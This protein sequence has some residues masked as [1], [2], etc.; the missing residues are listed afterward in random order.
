MN[1]PDSQQQLQ[2]YSPM[3]FCQAP[4]VHCL[5]AGLADPGPIAS[6]LWTDTELHS[7]VCLDSIVTVVD[8]HNLRK[9]LQEGSQAGDVN[10]AERQIAFADTILLNKVELTTQSFLPRLLSSQGIQA[11]N[12]GHHSLQPKLMYDISR[13]S[14]MHEVSAWLWS[15]ISCNAQ[16][17][18]LIAIQ[19]D[20]VDAG[21]LAECLDIIMG[22]NSDAAIVQTQH[23]SVPVTRLLNQGVYC[24]ESALGT[25]SGVTQ[26]K[27]STSAGLAARREADGKAEASRTRGQQN[28][29]SLNDSSPPHLSAQEHEA[30]HHHSEE[31]HGGHTS[32]IST[33]ALHPPR[34]V[35]LQR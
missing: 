18:L 14:E 20:L 15:W 23:S 1:N 5:Q 25:F 3:V 30:P 12:P 29:D 24:Q 11:H 21:D 2:Y 35:P 27:S 28:C 34:P 8:A 10:E 32:R 6:A 31:H 4:K 26:L 16:A 13:I 19:V 9:Q 17:G 22:I 33:V 7:S